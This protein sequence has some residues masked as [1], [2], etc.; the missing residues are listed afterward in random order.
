MSSGWP[1][2]VKVTVCADVV[3]VVVA[4]AYRRN[5]LI[6]HGVLDAMAWVERGAIEINAD[7]TIGSAVIYK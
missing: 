2:W 5:S 1:A 4:G 7:D 6:A 3:A